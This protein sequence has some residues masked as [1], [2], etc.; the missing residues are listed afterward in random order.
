MMN[1]LLN[2]LH[3][4]SDFVIVIVIFVTL[5]FIAKYI[6]KKFKETTLF[7]SSRFFNLKEYLP[8][9]EVGDINQIF[10]LSMI[11]LMVMTILYVLIPWPLN[12]WNMFF[13]DIILSVYLALQVEWTSFKN[14][15]ILFLLIPFSAI[16]W[17]FSPL[18]WVFYLDI[19]HALVFIYFIKI[20]FQK[21]L[22]YTE[23][24]GLG[25]TII[26][27]FLIIFVSFFVTMIVEKVSPFDSIVMVSNAFTSNGYAILGKTGIG[28]LNS[29]F[30]VWAG[31]FLSIVGSSTLTVAIVIKYI[32]GKFDRLE[33]LAKKDRK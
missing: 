14:K 3:G 8:E 4:I 10:Y 20:Y 29:V 23:E 30:L 21:F 17:F 26:L 33:D 15:V 22:K 1:E 25:I 13:L 28:K 31:F 9:E 19:V 7:K 27:L 6:S 32:N 2:I 12:S 24:N 5:V 11:F 18:S 16:A